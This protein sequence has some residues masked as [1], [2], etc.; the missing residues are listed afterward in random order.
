MVVGVT[1]GLLAVAACADD[2]GSDDA[3]ADDGAAVVTF[4]AGLAD[5][6]VDAAAERVP[7]V[8]EGVEGLDADIVFVQ[9]VWTPED[10]ATLTD[11]V[12][13]SYPHTQFL[14]PMPDEP[15]GDPAGPA[16]PLDES[17]PLEDCARQ[18]CA[19][20]PAEGLA[21]CVLE[22]CAVEFSAT[23]PE[24]QACLAANVG[25]TIDEAIETCTQGA[26]AYS[27]EGA[28][29]IGFLSTEPIVE[30]DSLVL[31][32]N[33]TRRAVMYAEVD[34]P[35]VGTLHLFGTHL[36]PVF[37]DVPFPGEGSWEDEQLDQIETVREWIDTKTD[38][39]GTIVLLGDFNVGPD[40]EL[41]EGEEVAHYEALV[42]DGWRN[43]YLEAQGDDA[44]CTFCSNN[45][46]VGGEGD[47]G[48][49]I[50]H[51]LVLNHDGDLAGERL[52][53]GSVDIEVDGETV[54]TAR[55]DHYAV[56]AVILP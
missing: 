3:S 5:G 50:D 16:C 52:L 41:F 56:G 37:S 20:V 22:G 51:V 35:D 36:S 48:A 43:A 46:L 31:D 33:L 9:E 34:D 32:S 47:S 1:L 53:D 26:A 19:D 13:D 6:F 17:Q 23:C 39:E 44:E 42:A 14:D 29:G 55:S 12:A 18:R 21:D 15:G 24:C 40:G 11:A 30:Q 54:S 38:G 25:S 49:V 8:V 10:V 4:N 45:P 27:Y 28:F 2:S 7:A